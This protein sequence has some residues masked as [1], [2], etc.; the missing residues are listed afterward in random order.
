MAIIETPEFRSS[1]GMGDSLELH[2]VRGLLPFEL[3]SDVKGLWIIQ[4]LSCCGKRHYFWIGEVAECEDVYEG[5]KASSVPF[6]GLC[7]ALSE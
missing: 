3:E 2:W 4:L 1:K 7:A 6:R 5:R